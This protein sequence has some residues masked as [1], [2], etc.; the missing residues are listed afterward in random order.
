MPNQK[1]LR[2]TIEWSD[3]RLRVFRENRRKAVAQ[4]VGAHYTD[5]GAEDK[6]PVNLLEMAVSIYRRHIVARNPQALVRTQKPELKP[7]ANTA[8]LAVNQHVR[9][10]KLVRVLQ[11]IFTDAFFCMGIAKVGLNRSNTVEVG[12]VYHNVGRPFVEAVSLDDLVIDMTARNLEGAQYIGNRYRLPLWQVRDSG[13]FDNVGWLKADN[14]KDYDSSERVEEIQRGGDGRM[15][16][17][18][19]A[20]NL[21]DLW[22]PGEG[23]FVTYAEQDLNMER[24]LRVMEWD[25]PEDGPYRFLGFEDV[26]DQLFPLPPVELWRDTHELY[27]MLFRKLGRQAE[28]QKTLLG[29]M[30]DAQRDGERIGSASDGDIVT[31]DNPEKA[32]ELTFGGV[33]PDNFNFV[34]AL[35]DLFS[36]TAGNLDAIG[37]LGPQAPTATQEKLI[38]ISSNKRVADL[39]ERTVDFVGEVMRDLAW[40]LWNDPLNEME[41]TKQVPGTDIQLQEMFGQPFHKG[42]WFDYQFTIQPYSMADKGPTDRMETIFQ[43][44]E[45]VYMPLAEQAMAQGMVLSLEQV[46]RLFA[47][48]NDMDELEEIVVF[49]GAPSPLNAA[50]EPTP[51]KPPVTKRTYERISRPG[52]TRKGSDVAMMALNSGKPLQPA[53][54]AGITRPKV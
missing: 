43:F 25:G 41:V 44:L 21:L 36:W 12:G 42:E 28:R 6:V 40:Y 47:Q 11:Q 53:E 8:R 9:D 50:E 30:G 51:P 34:I 48:Y 2:D 39:Q 7:Y 1:R 46:A 32:K 49:S 23:E 18:E 4:F 17:Y 10:I 38:A 20:V 13:L 3:K 37:G 19:E 33:N 24:P 15:E 31:M 52:A 22:L 5:G 45:R 29:V 16:E 54:M 27:N 26:P 14:L 35:R